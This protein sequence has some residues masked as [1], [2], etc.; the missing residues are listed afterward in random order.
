MHP[1]C[2]RACTC[3]AMIFEPHH[4]IRRVQSCQCHFVL[5]TK[6]MCIAMPRICHD[7]GHQFVE[8]LMVSLVAHLAFG[9]AKRSCFY[10]C[11]DAR[12]NTRLLVGRSHNGSVSFVHGSCSFCL[13]NLCANFTSITDLIL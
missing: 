9:V 11:L 10:L 3:T 12:N 2:D 13:L 1:V 5:Q 7:Y 8:D 4:Q 6:Y